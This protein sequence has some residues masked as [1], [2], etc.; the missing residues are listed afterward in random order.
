[1]ENL[2]FRNPKPIKNLKLK[3]DLQKPIKVN[4]NHYK[5]RINPKSKNVFIYKLSFVPEIPSDSI[6][7]RSTLMNKI[8]IQLKETF[9]IYIYSGNNF[10]STTDLEEEKTFTSI[11]KLQNDEKFTQIIISPTKSTVDLQKIKTGEINQDVKT[12][13]EILCKSLLKS[14]EL[15]RIGKSGYYFR[16]LEVYMNELSKL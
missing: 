6:F 8:H 5:M 11:Y 15:L 3:Q 2:L 14:N 9:Q 13:I 16:N 4:S 7:M 12:F 1:M 10:F